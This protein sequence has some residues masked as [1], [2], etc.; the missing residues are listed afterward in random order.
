MTQLLQEQADV[1]SLGP[2]AVPAK[3]TVLSVTPTGGHLNLEPIRTVELL[4]TLPGQPP[5]PSV[6]RTPVP[7][8]RTRSYRHGTVRQATR[9]PRRHRQW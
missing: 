5:V 7:L 8:T 6:L 2:I 9:V 4:V 3:A 1:R